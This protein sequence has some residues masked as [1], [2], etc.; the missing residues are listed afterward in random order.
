MAMKAIPM[1]GR[2]L[3]LHYTGLQTTTY[4]SIFP[5]SHMCPKGSTRFAVA[6]VFAEPEGL[7]R[8]NNGFGNV[9]VNNVRQQSVG[10]HGTIRYHWTCLLVGFG[11]APSELR[12]QPFTIARG[13]G[14]VL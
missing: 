14:F 2:R 3:P 1:R 10:R 7:V 12:F 9:L 11:K 8:P 4:S 13:R 6:I 5:M